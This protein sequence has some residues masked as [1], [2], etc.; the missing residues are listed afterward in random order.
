MHGASQD[1]QTPNDARYFKYG[2]RGHND[3]GAAGPRY[4]IL[5]FAFLGFIVVCLLER[6]LNPKAACL[7]RREEEKAEDGP[8]LGPGPHHMLTQHYPTLPVGVPGLIKPDPETNVNLGGAG[9]G[10]F[11]L[12]FVQKLNWYQIKLL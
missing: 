12:L 1:R 3:A 2:R 7:K 9:N 8:K 6:N 5:I 10:R 11:L 4:A